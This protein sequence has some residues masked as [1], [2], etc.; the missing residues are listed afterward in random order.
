MSPAQIPADLVQAEFNDI[1]SK[2]A[3]LEAVTRSDNAQ[4]AIR[5]ARILLKKSRER[6]FI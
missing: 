5:H 3:K 1:E 2:L 4:Q 6:L